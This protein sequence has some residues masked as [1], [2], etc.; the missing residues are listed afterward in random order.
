MS[1]I[2]RI[3]SISV[4]HELFQ[5]EKPKNPLISVIDLNRINP[6]PSHLHEHLVLGFYM[7]SL[8]N[9]MD[10]SI[11][12]GRQS[13]DFNEGSL[14]FMSPEQTTVAEYGNMDKTES[15][16]W[17]LCFHPDLIRKSELAKHINDYHFF[18]Y[19][20]NEALHVSESEKQ[21]I[22]DIVHSIE[23]EYSQNLDNHSLDLI[24]CHLEL[25]LKYCDR[26]YSR[27]FIT[28]H[29]VNKDIISV[30]ESLVRQEVDNAN[31]E[32]TGIPNVKSIA[33]KMGYSS[34]YLSD[35]LKKETGKNIQ[36]HIQLH[37]VEKAKTLLLNSSEPVYQIAYKMGFDYPTHFSKFFKKHT[38]VS[39]TAFRN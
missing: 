30:F 1:E 32:T 13:Y 35:L 12:Y 37:L 10:C 26:F 19:N 23:N 36:E 16:N 4:L 27:Q 18:S 22:T 39:P 6:D 15:E 17:T 20:V 38:G 34:S 3:N 29:A 7:I 21:M 25:L 31:L 9:G 33:D 8:K 11:K 5:Y 28:R 14:I 2:F 24:I